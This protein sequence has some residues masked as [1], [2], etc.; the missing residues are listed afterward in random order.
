[1]L[2]LLS[3]IWG[4]GE[5]A[6]ND[7]WWH[8]RTGQVILETG[9]IPHTDLYT[10]THADDPY[11]YQSWLMEM[12]LYLVYRLGGA[13]LTIFVHA[14]LIVSGYLL[15]QIGLLQLTQHNARVASALTIGAAALSMQD[16]AVRPQGI[17]FFLFGL[18]LFLLI[19]YRRRRG[20]WLWWCP[21]VFLVWVNAHGGFIFG[22]A[23]LGSFV[24]GRMWDA[25]LEA[26]A[27][28]WREVIFPGVL[29]GAALA[30]NPV[31]L[32]GIIHYVLSFASHPATRTLN[33][34][35]RP[36][37]VTTGLGVI[38]VAIVITLV[39]VCLR[40][41]YRPAT[42]ELLALLI[43][44]LLALSA[45]RNL[46]WFGFV[47]ASVVAV[48]LTQ[49]ALGRLTV[50][51][52]R[53]GANALLLALLVGVAVICLPWFRPAFRSWNARRGVVKRETPI[54]ATAYLCSK[55]PAQ[56]R[57]FNEMS[58]GSYMSWGCPRLPVFID[59]RF[60]LYSLP[61]WHE[62]L[63]ISAGR[64]DWQRW[65]DQH[66]ITHLLLSPENQSYLIAAASQSPCWKEIYRDDVSVILARTESDLCSR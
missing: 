45:V 49:G 10:F 43:F 21:L 32:L 7:F 51:R 63:M 66:G 16:W 42:F 3:A 62:Y 33:I 5:I 52:G 64:F 8:I 13:P 44:G 46:P 19:Q 60:E 29:S 11:V 47:S 50:E 6:P 34:E 18:T 22:L 54:S 26:E 30:A 2:V 61:E 28:P 38:F 41:H 59:T 36:L 39:V 48:V 56:A 4:W 15:L 31:G 14:V 23:L 24:I 12:G 53:S 20:Y 57:V 65:L 58:Y 55:L 27:L 17:S 9:R 40:R 1:V 37:T 25:R 35:F